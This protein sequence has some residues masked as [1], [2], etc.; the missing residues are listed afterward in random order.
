MA[1]TLDKLW[2]GELPLGV[3]FWVYGIGVTSAITIA[4]VIL[5]SVLG[6]SIRSPRHLAIAVVALAGG[7][8]RIFTWVAIWRSAD[9]YGGPRH[10][11]VLAKVAVVT[12]LVEWGLQ[13]AN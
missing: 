3:T 1:T 7:I 2:R 11:R 9:N 10:W 12:A 8:W 5:A 13:L 6:V 4:Q